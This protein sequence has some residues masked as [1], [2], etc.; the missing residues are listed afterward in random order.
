MDRILWRFIED[1]V[2]DPCF[3]LTNYWEEF[4]PKAERWL[5]CDTRSGNLAAAASTNGAPSN[6][7]S[8]RN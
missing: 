5:S 3:K 8:S 6:R 2:E 4:V 1:Q 7:C